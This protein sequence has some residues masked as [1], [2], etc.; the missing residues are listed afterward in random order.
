METN[1]KVNWTEEEEYTLIEAILTAGDGLRS[2]GLSADM[3]KNKTRLWN[4]VM[5]K[6]NFI[7]ENNRG[8]K[9]VEK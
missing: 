3:N 7:H 8:V 9:D 2:T 1:R 5:K 6:I 4:D